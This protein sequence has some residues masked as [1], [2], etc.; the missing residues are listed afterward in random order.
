MAEEKATFIYEKTLLFMTLPSRM[1]RAK[2][3]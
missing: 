3:L 1:K 2:K